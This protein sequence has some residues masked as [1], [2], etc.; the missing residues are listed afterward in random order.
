MIGLE[1][2]TL[3]GLDS[4]GRVLASHH[5]VAGVTPDEVV[6]R[7]GAEE[8]DELVERLAA[9]DRTDARSFLAE[10][11]RLLDERYGSTVLNSGP[12]YLI[13]DGLTYDTD[14]ELVDSTAPRPLP[15]PD[16]W[17][18][19]EWSELLAGNLGPWAV[20]LQDG[21]VA[22]VAHTP[23]AIERAAEVGIWTDPDFRGRGLGAATTARW[24]RVANG[25]TLFYS[26]SADNLSSQRVAARLGLEQLGWLWKISRPDEADRHAGRR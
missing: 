1:M 14:A 11:Q 12:G 9:V 23:A 25:R 19:D 17:E 8:P 3:W 4:R 22:A 18:L 10:C 2:E 5:L 20:A 26:T 15:C 6:V 13:P 7:Y 21:V 16:T 24:A